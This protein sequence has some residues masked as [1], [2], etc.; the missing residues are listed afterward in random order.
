MC[1][2]C[3]VLRAPAEEGKSAAKRGISSLGS[4]SAKGKALKT[5]PKRSQKDPLQH[6]MAGEAPNAFD[7]NAYDAKMQEL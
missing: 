7:Q 1:C 3:G 6:N 5:A 2:V 4:H